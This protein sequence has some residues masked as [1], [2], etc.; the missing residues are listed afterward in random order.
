VIDDINDTIAAAADRAGF[1]FV[2]PAAANWSDPARASLWWD[3][4]HPDDAGH[5][6][7]A[8][9]LAPLLEAALEG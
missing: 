1:R 3:E 4:N 7:I 2:D 6:R 9:R 5:Q 8:D